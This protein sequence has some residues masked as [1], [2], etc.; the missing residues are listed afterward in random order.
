MCAGACVMQRCA[1]ACSQPIP[2]GRQRVAARETRDAGAHLD[3]ADDAGRH[4]RNVD[5]VRGHHRQGVDAALVRPLHGQQLG[6]V[7][8]R[9]PP[10]RE[11]EHR[12]VSRTRVPTQARL[13]NTTCGGSRPSLARPSWCEFVPPAR[14][15]VR[16]SVLKRR[17][18]GPPALTPRRLAW[19]PAFPHKFLAEISSPSS[20]LPPAVAGGQ[21]GRCP[22][23]TGHAHARRHRRAT[24]STWARTSSRTRR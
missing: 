8:A 20:H 24:C 3:D 7:P 14:V 13:Q 21:A 17:D 6:L 18:A 1:G 4:E 19:L 12:S 2:V 9:R 22:S 10:S 5:V 15:I 11:H 16:A 23:T